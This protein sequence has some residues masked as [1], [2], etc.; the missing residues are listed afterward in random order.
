MF[1]KASSLLTS[2]KPEESTSLSLLQLSFSAEKESYS[3]LTVKMAGFSKIALLELARAL[4]VEE[5]MF[6]H[7]ENGALH[8]IGQ[9]GKTEEKK[10]INQAKKLNFDLSI[11]AETNEA[12]GV[13]SSVLRESIR[14]FLTS[15]LFS[16]S[17]SLLQ[18]G[19][20]R[21][22]NVSADLQCVTQFTIG[23]SHSDN[24]EI[25]VSSELFQRKPQYNVAETD[26]MD[27]KFSLP[28]S[29]PVAI[30][31]SELIQN[32]EISPYFSDPGNLK[33]YWDALYGVKLQNPSKTAIVLQN[34]TLL[35]Y[36]AECLLR[37]PFALTGNTRQKKALQKAEKYLLAFIA[38]AP[39]FKSFTE[40]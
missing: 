36:P 28:L 11:I 38:K 39:I 4:C 6:V 30:V 17:F 14:F 37:N 31:S 5:C 29:S 35:T 12:P 22:L 25:S 3:V 34:Q 40:E 32:Q 9:Y 26:Q 23:L 20:V 8:F 27:V 18:S 1:Q 16:K 13:P 24:V 10:I 21:K 19:F 2:S 33:R 15:F 7:P